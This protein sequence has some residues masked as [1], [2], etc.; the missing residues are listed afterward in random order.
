[1]CF[2]VSAL[3]T[4]SLFLDRVLYVPNVQKFTCP[5][6]S[7]RESEKNVCCKKKGVEFR[8]LLLIENEGILFLF[9][10]TFLFGHRGNI[11][12]RHHIIYH[13]IKA[14]FFNDLTIY[15]L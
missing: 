1:M 8:P 3:A 12:H 2:L 5:D 4:V 7:H 13:V 9:P 15:K 11:I 14:V 6:N 10:F